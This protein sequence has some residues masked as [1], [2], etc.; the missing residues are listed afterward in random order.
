M[1]VVCLYVEFLIYI[2]KMFIMLFSLWQVIN[3]FREVYIN[4]VSQ[5]TQQ[6]LKMYG[7]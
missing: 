7:N 3:I 2:C 6:M 4:L 1:M 5:G